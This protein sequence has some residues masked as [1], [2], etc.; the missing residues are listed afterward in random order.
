MSCRKEHDAYGGV[1]GV[2]ATLA[3][4][5]TRPTRVEPVDLAA[6]LVGGYLSGRHL[7]SPLPDVFEPATSSHH[8]ST[9]HSVA[10]TG[11]VAYGGA[12]QVVEVAE[13]LRRSA[14]EH[15]ALA[16]SQPEQAN[17]HQL[18][19][20]L[21]NVAAGAAIGVPAGYISHNLADS[22]TPRSIPLITRGL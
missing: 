17:Q 22:W 19:R 6:Q 18:L 15:A 2:V 5:L 4:A 21:K 10:V 11:L 9:M 16:Q 7:G 14:E 1:A 13:T 3:F 20:L 8:R 12:T